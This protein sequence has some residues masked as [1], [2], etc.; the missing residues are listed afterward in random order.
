MNLSYKL[1]GLF[2]NNSNSTPE[3]L[4]HTTQVYGNFKYNVIAITK[5][6]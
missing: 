2:L 1:I 4:A 6:N 5:M 3:P